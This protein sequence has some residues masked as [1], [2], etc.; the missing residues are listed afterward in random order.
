M[1]TYM[2]EEEQIEQIKKWW[3]KHGNTIST[4]ILI[5]V[6][7]FA[8]YRYWQWHN[9]KV[10]TQAS[11]LYEQMIVAYTNQDN[12]VIAS[13]ANKLV[14][15]HQGTVYSDAAHLTLAKIAAEKK[16]YKES[17]SHLKTVV[18]NDS[19]SALTQVAKLR[20]SRILL[21][22]KEYQPALTAIETISNDSYQ[23]LVNELRGDIYTAMGDFSK[24]KLAYNEA[25]STTR[26]Q[27][28]GNL[29]LEM[30]TNDVA[31]QQMSEQ[32]NIKTV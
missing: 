32:S 14:Q 15:N 1:S 26:K 27:K 8:G 16:A 30:K 6:V 4:I 24:A 3:N 13:R 7:C 17:I 9:Q 10:A 12:K 11:T 2:T 25:V 5:A 28:V 18:T 20:L 23:S 21:A 19:N 22:Q 29:F 31:R